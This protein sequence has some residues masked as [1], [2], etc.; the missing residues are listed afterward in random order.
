MKLAHHDNVRNML[1]SGFTFIRNGVKYDFPF[2]ETIQSLLPI[3]DEVVVAVGRGEDSTRK[4]IDE[5][6]SPKIQIIDT[7]WDE[8]QMID[9]RV[10]ANETSK[11]LRKCR[12][13]WCL[14]L[15]ADEVLHENEYDEVLKTLEI[16]R[17]HPDVDGILFPYH[18]FYGNYIT[19]NR[20]PKTYRNEIRIIRNHAN[21]YSFK[22]AQGF[23]KGND[24]KLKVIS[25]KAHIFHYAYSRHP[26]ILKNKMTFSDSLYRNGK[27]GVSHYSKE[28]FPW[29]FGLEHFQSSHPKIMEMRISRCNWTVKFFKRPLPLINK[30]KHL[31]IIFR[32]YCEKILHW[33]PGEYKNYKLLTHRT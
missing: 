16:G 7:V 5:L 15:Q 20:N 30:I 29:T 3:C 8:S 18:H 1:L 31:N 11:A 6:K 33:L 26:L 22:D 27:I 10:L 32:Y 19:V 24:Q 2:L 23:R 17:R 13:Q 4:K 21:I 14:Y 9:G 12:G 28:N 25:T